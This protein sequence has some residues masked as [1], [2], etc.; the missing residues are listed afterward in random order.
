MVTG[1]VFL[2]SGCGSVSTGTAAVGSSS[3]KGGGGGGGERE[4][5]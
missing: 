3:L 5:G 4:G 1:S 2:S